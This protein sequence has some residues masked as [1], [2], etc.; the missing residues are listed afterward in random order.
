MTLVDQNS[1]SRIFSRVLFVPRMV[2]TVVFSSLVPGSPSKTNQDVQSL[3][4]Q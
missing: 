3:L 2:T 1:M 4:S